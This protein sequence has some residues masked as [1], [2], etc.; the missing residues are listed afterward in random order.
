MVS[1]ITT[2]AVRI[3]RVSASEVM[4]VIIEDGGAAAA[5]VGAVASAIV[6][7]PSGIT[8]EFALQMYRR[9]HAAVNA[10]L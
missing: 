5:S 2:V 9:G 8:R 7:G 4:K 6:G 10:V 3:G 1:Q